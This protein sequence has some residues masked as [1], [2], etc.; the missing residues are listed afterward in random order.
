MET[1]MLVQTIAQILDKNATVKAVFGDPVKLES[2]TVSPIAVVRFE[3][4]GGGA[5]VAARLLSMFKKDA[6]AGDEDGKK[7][8]F[9]GGG[10]AL[11]LSVTPFG[12][13][14]ETDGH[15]SFT[16]LTAPA[17]VGMAAAPIAAVTERL[18]ALLS[19]PAKVDKHT[20]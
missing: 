9:A 7:P 2:Q 13:I 14:H 19:P 4:S 10:M 6:P 16:A 11:G 15:V 20:S 5:G 3:L 18:R 17:A 12:F 1:N 8:A